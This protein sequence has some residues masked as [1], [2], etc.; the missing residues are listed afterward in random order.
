MVVDEKYTTRSALLVMTFVIG[1]WSAGC[2]SGPQPKQGKAAEKAKRGVSSDVDAIEQFNEAVKIY[3]N[4]DGKELSKVASRLEKAISEDSNFGKAWFNLGVIREK[5]GNQ[6]GA[7][8][9]YKRAIETAPELGDPLVNMGLLELEGG[10]KDKA[11]RYFD[12]ALEAESYNPAAH[13]NLSVKFREQKEWKKAVSHARQALA[14][15]SEN[16]EAYEN[17]ARTYYASGAYDPA[18]LVIL[19]ALKKEK[20]RPDL[21]NIHG[22]VEL[23]R[24]NVTSAIEKF[25]TAIKIDPKHVPAR[26]NLGAVMLNVRDYEAA[27]A[28][29]QKVL[30]QQPDNT[31]AKISLAVAH[32]SKDNLEKAQAIY[33]KILNDQPEHPVVHYNL[34][35][36]QHEHLAR[37]AS[38]GIGRGNAPKNPVK[39]MEWTI[40]NLQNSIDHYKKARQYY[41]DYL[42]YTDSGS[43]ANRKEASERID[44]VATL[45]K[46][47][48]KQI[49]E[50]KKQKK[51][52]KKQLEAAEKAKQKKQS[53]KNND[54]EKK[55]SSGDGENTSNEGTSEGKSS[56]E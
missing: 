21:H 30:E 53:G 38:K 52:L 22:V 2:K 11:Y 19:N 14:G 37:D 54:A 47:T 26:M 28:H 13:N 15:D 33:D 7:R 50:L 36:I 8:T 12:R 10:A 25:Q 18:K 35:V 39:Q 31:E 40:T 48:K 17:L 6:K 29:F 27:L 20:E 56:G 43:T 44:Q 23:S 51:Q 55:K 42:S 5:Q 41:Q 34:G 16:L 32:R 49:P 9:A 3:E 4:T 24:D 1:V 46:E 45:I